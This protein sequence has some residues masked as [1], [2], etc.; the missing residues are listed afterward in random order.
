MQ[1]KHKKYQ[2][3]VTSFVKYVN[4]NIHT[5]CAH[6]QKDTKLNKIVNSGDK[7]QKTIGDKK[8]QEHFSAISKEVITDTG[9]C[10]K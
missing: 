1:Q 4:S 9:I 5:S 3:K 7:Y 2:S 6:I 8:H 10:M